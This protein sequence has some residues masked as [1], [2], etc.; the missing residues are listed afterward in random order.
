MNINSK[1]TLAKLLARENIT[2]QH[3]NFPTAFF[4][5]NGRVLGLPL[6]KDKGKDVY[7]LLVGHE[8]GHALF[9]PPEG[10]HGEVSNEDSNDIPKD[11][12][13][14]VED[15]RIEKLIQRQYPGLVASFKRGYKSLSNEDFF[16]IKDKNV[17]ALHFMNRLNLKAK[18]REYISVDFTEEEQPYVDMAMS[19]ETWDD[20]LNVCRKL[21]DYMKTLK[22][23][24]RV[25]PTIGDTKSNKRTQSPDDR[26][27]DYDSSGDGAGDES[28][29][30]SNDSE[31][32]NNSNLPSQK[33]ANN[34]DTQAI[35]DPTGEQK[36]SEEETKSQSS[37][38]VDSLTNEIKD[39]D[40]SAPA[41]ASAGSI[42]PGDNINE[43]ET[44]RAYRSNES[45]LLDR[46]EKGYQPL[47]IRGISPAQLDDIVIPYSKIAEARR[48]NTE[49]FRHLEAF[50]VSADFREFVTETDKFVS[51]MAKEFEMRKAAF[52]YS[53]SQSARSGSLDVSKLY[54]YKFS[55]DIFRRV[56][57]LADTKNHGMIMVVDYSGS[58]HSVMP[59]VIKQILT[60]A[61]F[62]KKI[63]IPFDVYGFTNSDASPNTVYNATCGLN[64]INHKGIMLTHQLSSSFSKRDYESAYRQLFNQTTEC[65]TMR[66]F[67]QGPS[68]GYYDQ[69]GGTPLNEVLTAMPHLIDRF[70][71]KH[72]VQ[73]TI[74]TI[75]T[76]GD[77]QHMHVETSYEMR[78]STHGYAIQLK[79]G[80]IKAK[81]NRDV[82]PLIVDHLRNK[83]GVITIGYFLADSR[84]SFNG[85][86]ARAANSWDPLVFSAARKA[87][88]AQ[89]F[90]SYEDTIGYDKYFVLRVDGRNLDTDTDDFEVADNAKAS[91]IRRAFKKYTTSKRQNR[92]LASQFAE[93]IS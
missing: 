10:W 48:L 56:T 65:N 4:D 34:I 91:D 46:D 33:D 8:V 27:D 43:I 30:E 88:N 76:D 57:R 58:M 66:Y 25:L 89:K 50:D 12:L 3:G 38:V 13:N 23:E 41:A 26:S 60:L 37:S 39:T 36:P 22:K 47:L 75:L 42:P 53:R 17:N 62:C 69:L 92:V 86:V 44:D 51:L 81:N 85:A 73:K 67:G 74:L 31:N 6:W 35:K 61:M 87:I 15:I 2:V 28:Y 59:Q 80:L 20:V 1:S 16:G 52:Q 79:N 9:T 7:D 82:T 64:D 63:N 21:L 93:A 90:V 14:V 11:Y 45:N 40:S 54:N 55:D 18:L 70:K 32:K 19:V 77:A 49:S 83:C 72:N 24:D 68:S 29:E 71:A 5:V 78:C 84:Y